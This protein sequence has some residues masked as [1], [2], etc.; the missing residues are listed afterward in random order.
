MVRKYLLILFELFFITGFLSSCSSA[1]DDNI[2][3]IDIGSTG[4]ITIE[5]GKIPFN[6]DGDITIQITPFIEF[7]LDVADESLIVI[8]TELLEIGEEYNIKI[9]KDE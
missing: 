8:P 6:V 9:T 1:N 5:K 7:K 4:P 3:P 2:S